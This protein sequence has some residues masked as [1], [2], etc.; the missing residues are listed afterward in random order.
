MVLLHAAK[1]IE[2]PED[3]LVYAEERVRSGQAASVEDVV[4]EALNEKKLADLRAELDAGVTE[5]DAGNSVRGSAKDLIGG[6][7][8]GL[9]F[10]EMRQRMRNQ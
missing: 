1:S 4:R 9:S 2:I 3:F 5:L 7:R 8:E 10:D 6:M